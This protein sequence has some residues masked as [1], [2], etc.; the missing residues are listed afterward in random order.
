MSENKFPAG[1][2]WSNRKELSRSGLHP[3]EMWG[4]QPYGEGARAESVVVSGGYED[5]HDYGDVIILTG[6]GGQSAPGSRP[7][8]GKCKS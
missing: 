1:T 2:S 7:T 4:I 5:D 8:I 6:H 3:P